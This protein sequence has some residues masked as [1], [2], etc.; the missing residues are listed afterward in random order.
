[1][2]NAFVTLVLIVVLTG[3]SAYR[4]SEQP[5]KKN[6][7]VL[8][9]GTP[10]AIVIGELGQPASSD[11]LD[12]KRKDVFSFVQGY[13]KGA[14]T[15]RAFGHAAMDVATLGVWEIAGMPIESS[16][17]GDKMAIQVTYDDKD[18]VTQATAYEN[19]NLKDPKGK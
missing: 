2:K 12:G 7:S 13:S 8:T 11:I 17:S 6:L 14:K 16:Y 4:A 1:M 19:G 15:G 5:D 3:C 9:I 10:R 18:K